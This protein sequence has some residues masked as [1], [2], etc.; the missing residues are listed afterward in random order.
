MH[1]QGVEHCGQS[2]AA[3]AYYMHASLSL[4]LSVLAAGLTPTAQR[5]P[6]GTSKMWRGL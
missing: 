2:A 4:H 3:K 6:A 5:S 1:Q